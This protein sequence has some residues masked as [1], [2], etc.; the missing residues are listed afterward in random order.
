MSRLRKRKDNRNLCD[1]NCS[2]L[3]MSEAV[4]R[5]TKDG[6]FMMTEV[7]GSDSYQSKDTDIPLDSYS[8]RISKI[9]AALA[10][11]D[12]VKEVK[13]SPSCSSSTSD[14]APAPA[15]APASE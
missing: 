10:G 11:M 15:P 9:E 4:A 6:Q 7:N 5:W 14:S 2:L 1:T 13:A 3:S 8:A 12:F